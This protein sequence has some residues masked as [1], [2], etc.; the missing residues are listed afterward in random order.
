[1]VTVRAMSQMLVGAVVTLLAVDAGVLGIGTVPIGPRAGAAH[2]CAGAL[3]AVNGLRDGSLDRVEFSRRMHRAGRTADSAATADRRSRRSFAQLSFGI[4]Q[5]QA[6]MIQT[7][8][9][10]EMT[11]AGPSRDIDE[12]AALCRD[13]IR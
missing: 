2:A 1:M 3:R 12:F 7:L 10:S 11:A 9:P 8:T 13:V 5:L 6:V 4:E